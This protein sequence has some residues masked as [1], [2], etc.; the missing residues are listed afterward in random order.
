[1]YR[2]SS[3]IHVSHTACSGRIPG[4]HTLFMLQNTISYKTPDATMRTKKM[5]PAYF[6]TYRLCSKVP[7]HITQHP[8]R[9]TMYVY[10]MH[11]FEVAIVAK[12]ER[13][14]KFIIYEWCCVNVSGKQNMIDASFF[15]AVVFNSLCLLFMP[16][17][18]FINVKKIFS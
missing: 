9:P 7:I 17:V 18:S 14:V 3:H 4:S 6:S 16:L 1:M 8:S 13:K 11:K 12:P 15:T 2:V 5:C 10:L